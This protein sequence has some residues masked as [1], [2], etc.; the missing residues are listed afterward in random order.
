MLTIGQKAPEFELRSE[1]GKSV[2]S[3]TYRGRRLILYFYPKDNTSGCTFEARSLRDGRAELASE[4]F[5]IV[6][7]SPDSVESHEGFC[8]KNE[9]NFTLLSDPDHATA[10]AYGV[11]VEKN[12]YGKK[13]MGIKRTT[14]IIDSEGR[15]EMIFKRVD[16]RNHWEQIAKWN[17]EQKNAI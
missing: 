13:S 7:I 3:T 12:M 14:F 11:W 10:E 4:G 8:R 17:N 15:V 9:L 6:G 1:Q 2:S 16:T 5:A